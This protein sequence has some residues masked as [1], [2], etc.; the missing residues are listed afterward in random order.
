MTQIIWLASYPRSGNT[1]MRFLL[2][3]LHHGAPFASHQVDKFIPSFH[4]GLT[5]EHFAH[6]GPTIVKTHLRYHDDMPLRECTTGAIYV[7]RDPIA[8]MAS[9]VS[10]VM[11]LTRYEDMTIEQRRILVSKIVSEFA[12]NCGLLGWHKAG[13]G[14]WEENLRSWIGEDRQFPVLAVRYETLVRD[15]MTQIDRIADFL[16]L[17]LSAADQAAAVKNAS[18]E[19]LMA[20][21][22]REIHHQWPGLFANLVK[23][24]SRRWRFVRNGSLEPLAELV[25]PDLLARAAD[26]LATSARQFGYEPG[27][28]TGD[29]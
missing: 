14:S 11:R 29:C 16:G 17:R 24:G 15:P 1:W 19:K 6:A 7:Y 18:Q 25:S 21:E 13:Y 28:A 20:M 5:S 3:N 8:V 12:D 27:I 26:A 4:K 10:Y 9:N 23:D 2:Y 22:E